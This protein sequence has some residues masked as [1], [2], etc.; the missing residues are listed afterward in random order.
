MRAPDPQVTARLQALGG[1]ARSEPDSVDVPAPSEDDLAWAP[2]VSL[3]G[4]LKAS[5]RARLP[6]PLREGRWD[7]GRRGLVVIAVLGLV[8]VLVAAAVVVR[9]RAHPVAAVRPDPPPGASVSSGPDPLA[10]GVTVLV[11]VEGKVR[12]PG[13]VTLPAGA[14]IAQAI[15]AAGG[16]LPGTDTTSLDLAQKVTDGQQLRVGEP[17]AV[18]GS[19]AGPSTGAASALVNINTASADQLDAL[20][21]IGPATA[22]KIIDWR[23]RH[24]AF[25]SVRQ[26]QQ[27]PGIGP[28]TYEDIA[29][30]VTV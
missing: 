20:P 26:L 28:S 8:A 22:A 24:G 6:A 30:L 15:A 17:A 13:L 2:P 9:S 14:R 23:A 21:H 10:A 29:P 4:Y 12:R 19:T 11:D 7:P 1:G 18:P 27:V 16:A 3:S 25:T 5:L